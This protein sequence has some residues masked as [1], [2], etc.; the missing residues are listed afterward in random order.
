MILI[1]VNIINTN[2]PNN[3][4]YTLNTLITDIPQ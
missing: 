2:L 1:C 4:K 3:P